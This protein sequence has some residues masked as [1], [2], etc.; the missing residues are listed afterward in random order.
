MNGYNLSR[1][2]FD[3]KFENKTKVRAIHSD[4]FMY[5]VDNW[6]RMGKKKEFGL[7]TSFTME[8]LNIGSYNTYKKTLQDL[9]DFGFITLVSDSKNQ[10]QSKVISISNID[11]ASDEPNDKALD[12]ARAL[13]NDKPI[14]KPSDTIDEL[15]KLLNSK[16]IKLLK[17]NY[18]IVNFNL[19][20]WILTNKEISFEILESD[21]SSDKNNSNFKKEAFNI[22]WD[23]YDKKQGLEA[24]EKKFLK[25][26]KEVIE[27]ILEVVPHYVKSTPDKKYRKQP[28][29]WLNNKG[30]NDEI[31]NNNNPSN[32]PKQQ[33]IGRTPIDVLRHNLD[34]FNNVKIPD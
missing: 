14:N 4:M 31:I 8:M 12:R 3:F 25:L 9:I 32:E 24:C 16:T 29:T 27:K 6:N 5:I 33:L 11:K 18:E 10:H 19:E 22:F 17:T 7:P 20:K 13:A 1:K 21:L 15:Y 26:S 30:W 34:V 28:S 2:W 23:A